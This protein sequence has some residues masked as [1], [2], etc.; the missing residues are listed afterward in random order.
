MGY[1]LVTA[2]YVIVGLAFY[3]TFPLAKYCIADNFIN[4]FPNSNLLMIVVRG[5]LLIQLSTI[6][7]LIGMIWRDAAANVFN[8]GSPDKHL[9]KKIIYNVLL[10]VLCVIIAIVLPSIG[11]VI[12]VFGSVCGFL[13]IYFA[14]PL[15]AWNVMRQ[16]IVSRR[17]LIVKSLLFLLIPLFGAANLVLNLYDFTLRFTSGDD[18]VF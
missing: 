11:V 5:I 9:M 2:T 18:N 4:N 12:T 7:P 8:L 1:G 6:Y 17:K 10:F 13:L 14:P 3:L 15:V 16:E